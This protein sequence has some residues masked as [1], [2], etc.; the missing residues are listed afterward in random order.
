MAVVYNLVFREFFLYKY[1]VV[2]VCVCT[3][4]HFIAVL[5]NLVIQKF[6]FYRYFVAVVYVVRLSGSDVQLTPAIDNGLEPTLHNFNS[7]HALCALFGIFMNIC[8]FAHA[9]V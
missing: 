2:V 3:S 8:S 1:F 5:H 9:Q 4:F 6:R 7:I